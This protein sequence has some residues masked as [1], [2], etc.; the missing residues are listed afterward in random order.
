MA[1]VLAN[2]IKFHCQTLGKGDKLVVFIHGLVMDNLSS[3]YFTLGNKVAQFA[4]VL[5]YDLRGHGKSDRPAAGYDIDTMVEDLSELLLALNIQEKVYLVGNSFGGVL[6]LAFAAKYPE[7]T[8]GLVLA[9]AHIGDQGFSEEMVETLNL[10]GEARDI[11]IME[12]FKNWLG[13]HSH[14]KRTRLAETAKALVYGTSLVEDMKNSKPFTEKEIKS[15]NCPVLAIY[16]ENSDIREKGEILSAQLAN[17][18][19]VILEGCT[20][21]VIWE[22]TEVL[23]SRVMDW[24]KKQ[25]GTT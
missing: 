24:L 7:K 18:D 16:G 23:C 10:K 3:W 20:H 21:S 15:V 8:A 4:R 6:I 14:R 1:E 22:A 25:M 12:S 17:C 19:H 9:D 13:R 11:K 2:N 5:M